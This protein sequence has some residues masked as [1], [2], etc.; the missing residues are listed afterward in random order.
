MH[1]QQ[2]IPYQHAEQYHWDNQLD[3]ERILNYPLIKWDEFLFFSNHINHLLNIQGTITPFACAYPVVLFDNHM[4]SET[5]SFCFAAFAIPRLAVHRICHRICML[6][7]YLNIYFITS[8]T[9]EEGRLRLYF[10]HYG[11]LI[12]SGF[13]GRTCRTRN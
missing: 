3:H 13:S 7:I 1:R 11:S 4:R 10:R 9:L 12:V 5:L 2:R 8:E 6:R